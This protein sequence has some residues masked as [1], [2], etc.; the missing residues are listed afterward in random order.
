VLGARAEPA[1]DVE[2]AAA[3]ISSIA[4]RGNAKNLSGERTRT[5]ARVSHTPRAPCRQPAKRY[6][7][8]HTAREAAAREYEGLI[9]DWVAVP[10]DVDPTE[11]VIERANEFG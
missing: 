6:E 11:Y 1:V 4:P 2:A 9:S 3:R 5:A 10:D 8:E 7:S